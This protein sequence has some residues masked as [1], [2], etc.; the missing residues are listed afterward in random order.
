MTQYE[1]DQKDE[2]IFLEQ[3]KREVSGRKRKVTGSS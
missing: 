3:Q 2:Q 1:Q